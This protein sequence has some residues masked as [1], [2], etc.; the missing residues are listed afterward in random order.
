[1]TSRSKGE[2][3]A[4]IA[5]SLTKAQRL[6][7]ISDG[8]SKRTVNRLMEM[9]LVSGVTYH[10]SFAIVRKWSVLGKL[11]AAHLTDQEGQNR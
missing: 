5:L 6:V 11:V 7:F 2:D 1:M 8:G 3:A 9:G 10:A 4:G